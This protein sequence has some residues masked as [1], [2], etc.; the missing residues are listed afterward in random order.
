MKRRAGGDTEMDVRARSGAAGTTGGS[1]RIRYL[2]L[3]LGASLLLA[4][5]TVA[6]VAAVGTPGDL[7]ALAAYA[8]FLLP[9]AI[10]GVAPP[11]YIAFDMLGRRNWLPA[12]AA[13]TVAL[14]VAFVVFWSAAIA[15]T[16]RPRGVR[17]DPAT[18]IVNRPFVRADWLRY[19]DLRD[20]MVDD[21]VKSSRL[22]GMTPVK[23]RELLGRPSKVVGPGCKEMCYEIGRRAG[24]APVV[25]AVCFG[26]S[27]T[28]DTVV[29]RD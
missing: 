21:L 24:D 25:L 22:S 29:L 17:M 3:S 2:L 27:G 28:V 7:G 5:L 12:A 14:L 15:V 8:P 1:A 20:R 19:P 16:P 18:V 4:L 10:A 11:S 23:V 13:S 26:T 6:Y 9:A